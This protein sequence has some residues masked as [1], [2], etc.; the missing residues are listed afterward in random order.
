M[1]NIHR[2]EILEREGPAHQLRGLYPVLPQRGGILRKGHPRADPPAPVQQGGAGEILRPRD[3]LRRAGKAD[4]RRRRR[5]CKSWGSPTAVGLCTG[6]WG[7][8][9]QRPTIWRCGCRA[10]TCTGRYP[11]AAISRISRRAGPRSGSAARHG[12]GGVRPHP[13][14]LGPGRGKDGGRHPGKLPADRTEAS[15]SPRPCDP[16]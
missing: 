7:S 6:I 15:S 4:P 16:T 11:P 10:R 14:R 5:S 2:D 12:Q 13:Q 1:T 3:L 8:P 9:R